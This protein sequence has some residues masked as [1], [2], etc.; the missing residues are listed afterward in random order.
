[1]FGAGKITMR[2]TP[3]KKGLADGRLS[4]SVRQ[5]FVVTRRKFLS[6]V[7]VGNGQ[8]LAT[9]GAASSQDATAI[10]GGH[11]LAETM[12]VHAAAIVGLKCSFHRYITFI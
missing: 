7:L 9:L 1:M 3:T 8:L 4:A 12:L 10:L 6:V 5:S 11:A 2:R